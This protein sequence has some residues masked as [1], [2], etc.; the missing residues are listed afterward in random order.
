MNSGVALL[1]GAVLLAGCWFAVDRASRK[2]K[3]AFWDTY[4]SYEGFSAQV[5]AEK[6]R[7]VRR[8]RGEIAAIKSV[9]EEHP[10][11]SLVIAKRYV[12]DL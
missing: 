11:A 6:I 1:I 7:S 4:G 5:D 2:Q 3:Q 12:E 10:L 9:R 8:D